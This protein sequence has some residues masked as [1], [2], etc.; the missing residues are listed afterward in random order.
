M[1][2]S[3][4]RGIN[5]RNP[6]NIKQVTPQW[7]GSLGLDEKGHAIFTDHIYSVRAAVRQLANYCVRDGAKTLNEIFQIYAPTDDGNSPSE[8]AR[9]VG[10]NSGLDPDT[11]IR[12]FAPDGKVNDLSGLS[13]ILRA[14]LKFENFAGYEIPE[15]TLR[16]GAAFYEHDFVK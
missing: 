11:R 10:K 5:N 15:E 16:A 12:L 2:V 13:D 6:F 14:M 9:Y 7:D 3:G 4:L 1:S 8:Y